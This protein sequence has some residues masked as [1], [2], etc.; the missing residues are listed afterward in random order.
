[1]R[2]HVHSPYRLQEHPASTDPR[3]STRRR[4]TLTQL[5]E[6]RTL[7]PQ[8][9]QLKFKENSV[10]VRVGSTSWLK[11]CLRQSH[12]SPISGER[13]IVGGEM[14]WRSYLTVAQ[15]LNSEDT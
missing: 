3:P 7:D 8:P 9:L 5:A 11:W 10:C 2:E 13:L 15:I 6:V 4:K 12:I 1:M 14:E